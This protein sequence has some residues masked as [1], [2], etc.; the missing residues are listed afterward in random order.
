MPEGHTIHRHALDQTKAV[1][2]Q[3]LAV[4]SPQGR[5]AAE[6]AALDGARLRTIEA[7]GKHLFYRW[8]KG[9]VVHIHLG[10]AG[11]FRIHRN[12]AGAPREVVRMRLTGKDRTVDLAGPMICELLDESGA[13]AILA[14]LGPDPLRDDADPARAWAAIR[15]SRRSIGALLM[16][17]SAMAGVGNIYRCEVLYALGI[18]PERRG[19]DVPQ[20]VFEAMWSRLAGWMRIGVRKNKILTAAADTADP[21]AGFYVYKR[22][23]CARCG[24]DIRVWRIAARTVYACES[25]QR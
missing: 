18:H 13:R 24:A 6:A 5:F 22:D 16:D 14:R 2:G 11:R 23:R 12:P 8:D 17:Q 4:T 19:C 10:L 7:W 21:E 15:K 25:C 9:R 20:A 3:R 1:G